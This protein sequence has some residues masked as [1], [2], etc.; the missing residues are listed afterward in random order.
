MIGVLLFTAGIKAQ[1]ATDILDKAA[2]VYNHSNGISATFAIRTHF[3]QQNTTESFEG[4]IIMKGDKFTLTTPDLVTW[5]DGTTQW[6]Y[7]T[8]TEEVNIS[9]PSGDDLQFTNPSI[10]LNSYKKGFTAVYKGE[11]TAAN[12]KTA[13]DIEL[14]PKKKGDIT[15]VELR[16]EKY[17]GLPAGIAVKMKNGISNS[18]VISDIKTGTNQPDGFF[19][20][21]EADYP[22]AEIIDLR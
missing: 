3:E 22:D 6:T 7:M 4:Q 14:T 16:I 15:Q 11:S 9:T 5:Y 20:F 13:Y 1:N 17:S 8:R 18:I 10:L 21:N 19:T 2:A 12:G